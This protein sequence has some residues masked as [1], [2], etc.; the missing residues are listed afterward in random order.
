MSPSL[1]LAA[2]HIFLFLSLDLS[3]HTHTSVKLHL[4]YS[5]AMTMDDEDDGRREKIV[6]IASSSDVRVGR[7]GVIIL[8]SAGSYP[9]VYNNSARVC[10][11]S[12]VGAADVKIKYGG[13]SGAPYKN[14]KDRLCR[15][16]RGKTSCAPL[17]NRSCAVFVRRA[18][19]DSRRRF[20]IRSNFL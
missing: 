7:R 20:R 6:I 15:T 17:Y 19:S 5:T 16:I 13:E 4:S 1:S 3:P 9:D 2:H 18:I 14:P 10:Q 8:C 12:R 11:L